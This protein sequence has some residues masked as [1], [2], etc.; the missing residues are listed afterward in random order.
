MKALRKASGYLNKA[1]LLAPVWAAET[2]E[3]D[4]VPKG[5]PWGTLGNVRVAGVVSALIQLVLI[6]AALVAFFY[7]L[8]GGVKW[9]MS[10]GDKEQT[11][12]AQGTIT[13]ALIGLLIVF[14][15]WAIIKLIETFFG[16]SI[17]T[18]FSIP[19]VV[20]PGSTGYR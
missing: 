12:K 13:A 9:I 16:L 18:K 2:Q 5:E 11:A 6:I 17:I 14:T 19:S 8:I 20:T 1:L 3:I 10:G 4:L 15:A 7:L